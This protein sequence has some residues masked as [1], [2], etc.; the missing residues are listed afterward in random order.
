MGFHHPLNKISVSCDMEMKYS[1][2]LVYN[3][4]IIYNPITNKVH[5]KLSMLMKWNYIQITQTQ[6]IYIHGDC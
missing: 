3:Q 6:I 1:L 5:S 4:S 2:Q